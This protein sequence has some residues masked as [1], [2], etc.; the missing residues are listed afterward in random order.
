MKPKWAYN[1]SVVREKNTISFYNLD[2]LR[3]A[4]DF[5]QEIRSG[6]N[7][8]YSDFYI[9]FDNIRGAF[10][11]GAT[12][13]SGLLD[14]Y[15]DH[16]KIEFICDYAPNIIYTSN[17]LNPRFVSE[18]EAQLK[19]NVLN[20]IWK[21]TNDEDIF[22]LVNAFI[23]ELS[24]SAQFNK[25]VLPA[26]EW[27]LNEV[28][29]NVIQH[30][31]C[32]CGYAMGQIH[33]TSKHVAFTI[34]DHGQGIFNSLKDSVHAPRFPLDALT[35]CVKEG[36]T[37][38]KKIGQGNGLFGLQKIVS[39]NKGSMSISSSSAS[40]TLKGDEVKSYKEL[41]FVSKING[42][43]TIDFQLDYDK[44]I[45]ISDLLSFKGIKSTS[46]SLYDE[47]IE[48][49]NGEIYYLIKEKAS[50]TGT[51]QSGNRLR[52]DI[53]NFY[54]EN[55]RTIVL[56]FID[57]GVISSSFADELIGKLLIEFGFIDFNSKV[58]IKNMNETVSSIAQRSILQRIKESMQ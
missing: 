52:N 44:E 41:P 34:F 35:L 40:Y 50:G 28:M 43:T 14:Y 57:I 9:D 2:K 19:R 10:P 18:D 31:N 56:D 54:K 53:L 17:I 5:I 6:I 20:K 4:S 12:P 49:E 58:R 23:E 24:K 25:G 3:V 7:A 11:N 27:T 47:N 16:E 48:N 38:D 55:N 15:R 45:S 51:R 26:L 37:R 36:V 29:D 22:K 42:C 46:I 32:T 39:Q 33:Q 8:G 30:S 13:I 1:Q 21:F